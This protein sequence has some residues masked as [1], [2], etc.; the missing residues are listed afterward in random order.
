MMMETRTRVKEKNDGR[1]YMTT[2][3]FESGDLKGSSVTASLLRR[4][5]GDTYTTLGISK[6]WGYLVFGV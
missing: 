1:V 6:P 2:Y 3:S 4:Y 5:V